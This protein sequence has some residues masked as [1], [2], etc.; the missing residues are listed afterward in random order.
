MEIEQAGLLL[1]Q[2]DLD[3]G[4]RLRGDRGCVDV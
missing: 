3:I 2:R 1:R 4:A